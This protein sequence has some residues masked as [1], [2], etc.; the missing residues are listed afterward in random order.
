MPKMA[1]RV[2]KSARQAQQHQTSSHHDEEVEL[3]SGEEQQAE[4]PCSDN[5]GGEAAASLQVSPPTGERI[6]RTKCR[7]R[8]EMLPGQEAGRLDWLGGGVAGSPLAV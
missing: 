5:H 8:S 4:I 2:S 1:A 3:K 7:L 6:T